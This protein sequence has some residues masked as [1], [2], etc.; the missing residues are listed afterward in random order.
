ME[1]TQGDFVITTDPARVDLEVVHGF[2]RTA[3]W[4]EDIPR[5]LVE[6]SVRNSINFVLL[7]ADRQVGFARVVTDRATFAWIADVF[8]L[9]SWRGRGLSKWLMRT[10]LAH[11]DLQGLRRWVLATRD[12]HGLYTQV[13]FTPLGR[14][15]RFMERSVP[16]P[17]RRA[18]G[19]A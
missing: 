16:D 3:Y 8:V 1:W 14:P 5:E 12:A 11:P 13:G 10:V 19:G 17:Y 18:P 9:E 6:R 7:H 15:E 2:L 4:C